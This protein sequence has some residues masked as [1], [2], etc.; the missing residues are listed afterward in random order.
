MA[1]GP[2]IVGCLD[3][4]TEYTDFQRFI[5]AGTRVRDQR[6]MNGEAGSRSRPCKQQKTLICRDFYG[7]D[8]TRTRDLRRATSGP[9]NL[10]LPDNGLLASEH[11]LEAG[12]PVG[13]LVEAGDY[14][15]SERRLGVNDRGKEVARAGALA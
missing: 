13:V 12:E 8:G 4:Q 14:V 3:Q 11:P 2:D 7:S 5:R 15:G 6:G 1:G 10:A 9:P